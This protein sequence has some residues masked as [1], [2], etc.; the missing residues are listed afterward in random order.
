MIA[1]NLNDELKNYLEN[2]LREIMRNKEPILDPYKSDEQ[3]VEFNKEKLSFVFLSI[4]L[5][6]YS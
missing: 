5:F 2:D 3:I 4:Y 6:I 1:R